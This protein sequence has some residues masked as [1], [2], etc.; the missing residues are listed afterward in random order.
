[1]N[2]FSI[3]A[4]CGLALAAAAMTQAQ[5]ADTTVPHPDTNATGFVTRGEY[6]TSR[7]K[8]IMKAD[9][10]HD[11]A[12]SRAEWGEYTKAVRRDLEL[13]GV[14]GAE[15]IGSGSWWTALDANKDNAVTHNEII[16][17]TSAKF[18]RYDL[19]KDNR[20]SRA[21]AEQVRKAGEA[22]IAGKP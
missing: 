21:E 2:S 8:F 7:E 5:A 14:K 18:D 6:Q 20:I 15:L 4:C 9:T 11:G 10:N 1:M 19:N 22:V 12:V 16:A 17:V 3:A 13:N